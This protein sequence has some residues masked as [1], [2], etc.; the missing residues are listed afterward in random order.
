MLDGTTFFIVATANNLL[1]PMAPLVRLDMAPALE[2][3][4]VAAMILKRSINPS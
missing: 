1:V 2:A 3:M 4:A